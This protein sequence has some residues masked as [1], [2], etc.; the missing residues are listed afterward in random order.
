MAIEAG[1]TAARLLAEFPDALR[2]GQLVAYFQPEIELSS[3]RV[4]AAESL[5]R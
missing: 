2:G 4:V 1:D 3:G 5:A